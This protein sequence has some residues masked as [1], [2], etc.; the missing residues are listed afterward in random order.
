MHSCINS[1]LGS[2]QTN[3]S[4]PRYCFPPIPEKNSHLG[5]ISVSIPLICLSWLLACS[6]SPTLLYY[7]P[8]I[9]CTFLN[10]ESFPTFSSK[11]PN[12]SSLLFPI[13]QPCLLPLFCILHF[14]FWIHTSISCLG[15]PFQCY[16]HPRQSDLSAYYPLPR[17]FYINCIPY[18]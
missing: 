6:Q 18:S 15:H 12:Y 13:S 4:F 2:N 16:I 7:A 1:S 3:H 10:L 8:T 11:L 9:L 5:H 17:I 14:I